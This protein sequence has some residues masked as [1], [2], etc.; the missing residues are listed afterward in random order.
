LKSEIKDDHLDDGQTAANKIQQEFIGG[1]DMNGKDMFEFGARIQLCKDGIFSP[2][3]LSSGYEILIVW[4][5]T[6]LLSIKQ[7]F[8]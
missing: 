7:Y 5:I 1:K 2:K 3:R 4:F 8:I 6:L